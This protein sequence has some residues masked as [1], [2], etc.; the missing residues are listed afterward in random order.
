[1]PI[2]FVLP[3]NTLKVGQKIVVKLTGVASAIDCEVSSVSGE[4]YSFTPCNPWPLDYVHEE[5]LS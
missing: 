2:S 5:A 1:M 4:L 3:A